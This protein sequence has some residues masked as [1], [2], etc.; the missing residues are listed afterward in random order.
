M[1]WDMKVII[2]DEALVTND[3]SLR[4]PAPDT[5]RPEGGGVAP[6]PRGVVAPPQVPPLRLKVALVAAPA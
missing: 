6:R 3:A 4:G 5:R 2:A 1:A